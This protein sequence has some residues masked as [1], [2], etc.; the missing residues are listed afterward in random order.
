MTHPG[1][2]VF[3]ATLAG[4]TV[5]YLAACSG[6][7]RSTPPTTGPLDS[8]ASFA[9]RGAAANPIEPAPPKVAGT[10]TGTFSETEGSHTANGTVTIAITQSGRS[11]SGTFDVTIGT[12]T[13]D[14][15]LSGK[16]RAIKDGARLTFT[17]IDPH[18][19][20]AAAKARVDEK[21]LNGTAYV[22]PSGS[23]PAVNIKYKTKLQ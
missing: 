18:G 1:R 2:R 11:I 13:A 16:V 5:L 4:F 20:N 21:L 15:T 17:I 8:A 14:L 12:K 3:N 22:A 19:R 10:Y 6:A 23:K 7:T 9:G